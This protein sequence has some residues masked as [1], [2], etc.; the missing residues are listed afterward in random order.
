M[1]LRHP[2]RV[3]LQLRHAPEQCEALRMTRAGM[4]VLGLAVADRPALE[5]WEARLTDLGVQHSEP[6][7]AHL[8]W[9]IDMTGPDG[10]CIQLHTSEDVSDT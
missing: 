4:A 9:A 2:A 5:Q 8:G 10:L 1:V 6:Y 3:L 7:Q